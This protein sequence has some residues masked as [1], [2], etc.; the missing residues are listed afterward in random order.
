MDE[1]KRGDREHGTIARLVRAAAERHGDRPAIV[2]GDETLSFARLAGEVSLA[3]RALLAAGIARGD[4]VALW[5]PN[6][7]RWIVAAL[8]VHSTGAALV[9]INTRFKGEEAAYVLAKSSARTWDPLES[10]CRHASL[11]IL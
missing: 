6:G 2:D 5:A 1:G 3:A 8:A 4:R 11:S 10:T 9:P 7:W